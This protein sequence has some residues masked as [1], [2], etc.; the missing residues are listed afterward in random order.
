VL[1]EFKVVVVV[2]VEFEVEVV[3]DVLALVVDHLR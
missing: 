3:I 1:V 2:L